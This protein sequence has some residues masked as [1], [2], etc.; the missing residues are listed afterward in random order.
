MAIGHVHLTPQLVTAVR[1]AVEIVAIAEEHTRLTRRGRR[2]NGLCPLHREKTP[3][4]TVDPE[5]GLFYCFGCGQGGDA[6]KLHMLLSGDDFPAAIE[7]L[8]R[9]FGVPL[10]SAPARRGGAPERDLEA[11]LAEAAAWF[12]QQLAHADEPRRYLEKRGIDAELVQRYG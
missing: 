11:V 3:S 9:R 6:I 2:S 1:Q 5:Q 7:S 10:P 8:A 4:F 12:S